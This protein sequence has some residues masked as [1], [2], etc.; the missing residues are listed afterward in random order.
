MFSC[1]SRRL[2]GVSLVCLLATAII[3][4][5]AGAQSLIR[6]AE[7]EDTIRLY[8]EPLFA[9]A[10]L[11]PS[12]VKTF[13]VNDKSLNAFVAGGQ[14]V[15]INTGLITELDR[16]SQ[17]IGVIA[18]ETG[19]IKAAHLSRFS[20]G[21]STATLPTI[22]GVILGAAAIAAGEPDVGAALLLGGQHIG[23]RAILSFTRDQ[24]SMAD[25]IGVDLLNATGQ[26]SLGMLETFDRFRDQELWSEGRKDPFA[27]THPANDERI[28]I[29]Q[30]RVDESP[31][32]D[33]PD[34]AEF[35]RRYERMQAK[36]RGFIDPP[37]VTMA[38]Y[39]LTDQSI[40]AK[41]ARAISLYRIPDTP[42]ALKG[43]DELLA[44]EPANPYFHELKGQ[45]L[46]EDKSPQEALAPFREAVRLAPDQPLLRILLAH[47]LDETQDVALGEEALKHLNLAL[48][49]E[50][51]SSFAWYLRARIYGR[52]GDF[53]LAEWAT[54]ERHYSY[55]NIAQALI[56]ANKA[57]DLLPEGTVAFNRAMDIKLAA[58]QAKGNTRRGG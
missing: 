39:P 53:G 45:I 56:H 41:Y 24:E 52:R 46:L 42:N 28:A 54:A 30:P 38:I 5:Q 21:V 33:K 58:A 13:L 16:P 11:A 23:Q 3:P 9:A 4:S 34:S 40:P 50:Q 17:L 47:S 22:L 32:R 51:D 12:D 19:H 43:I 8:S 1:F 18:H 49:Y 2:V 31:Y 27:R 6:D 7:I 14:N 37:H 35:V 26:T 10:G 15:F 25:Q 36:L 57:L 20:D 48:R 29:L 44:L 55:N